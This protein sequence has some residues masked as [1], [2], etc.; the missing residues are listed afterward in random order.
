MDLLIV[1]TEGAYVGN[2]LSLATYECTGFEAV[3]KNDTHKINATS[4]LIKRIH[5][6]VGA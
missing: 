5:T 6:S 1:D 4:K 2:A 3:I